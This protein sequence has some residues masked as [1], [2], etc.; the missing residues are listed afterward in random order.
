MSTYPREAWTFGTKT[1]QV[2]KI[3]LVEYSRFGNS[4]LDAK[5]NCYFPDELFR[6]RNAAFEAV[7]RYLARKQ[8]AQ[9]RRQAVIKRQ[10]QNLENQRSKA[11]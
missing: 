9:D 6:S 2:R 5:G 8:L 3:V 7:E 1:C 10:R 11:K 4:E